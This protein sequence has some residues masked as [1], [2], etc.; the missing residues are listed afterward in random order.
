MADVDAA[1]RKLLGKLFKGQLFFFAQSFQ[2]LF[3]QRHP[4]FVVQYVL[5]LLSFYKLEFTNIFFLKLK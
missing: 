4:R 5:I 2:S 3:G 1:L